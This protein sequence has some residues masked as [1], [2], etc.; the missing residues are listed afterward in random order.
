MMIS[1]VI[2]HI[3]DGYMNAG[4]FSDAR[5][6]EEC[7]NLNSKSVV[8]LIICIGVYLNATYNAG[9]L[10]D[11]AIMAVLIAAVSTLM[12]NDF[13]S[14]NIMKNNFLENIIKRCKGKI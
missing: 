13:D 1:V 3:L 11:V 4:L 5:L 6:Y 14:C 2:G 9:I 7:P 12:K 10:S 8:C